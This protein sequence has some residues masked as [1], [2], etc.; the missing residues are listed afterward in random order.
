MSRVA[1]W[2]TLSMLVFAT[3][4]SPAR[5]ESQSLVRT[6]QM[7]GTE[8]SENKVDATIGIAGECLQS[9]GDLTCQ[10]LSMSFSRDG[11]CT[12]LVSTWTEH[13]KLVSRTKEE[14][15]WGGTIGPTGLAGAM[16]TTVLAVR[17]SR[18]ADKTK[19]YFNTAGY[20]P[21]PIDDWSYQAT[22]VFTTPVMGQP[23]PMPSVTT[24]VSSPWQSDKD[25]SFCRPTRALLSVT[26]PDWGRPQ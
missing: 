20:G 9:G 3:S 12:A 1:I 21:S 15:R 16:Q 22:N 6:S 23:Q 4:A 18:L 13:L 7:W 11:K 10:F 26:I 14:A 2:T 19:D 5:A 24:N 17:R 8:Q 25:P